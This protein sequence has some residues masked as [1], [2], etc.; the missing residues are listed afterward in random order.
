MVPSALKPAGSQREP[1]LP[2]CA[3]EGRT[4][5][6]HI[7]ATVPSVSSSKKASFFN[8]MFNS[9]K[10]AL[11]FSLFGVLALNVI[12]FW[13]LIHLTPKVLFLLGDLLNMTG[14]AQVLRCGIGA[15][16]RVPPSLPCPGPATGHVLPSRSSSLISAG[17]FKTAIKLTNYETRNSHHVDRAHSVT[18]AAPLVQ[19]QGKVTRV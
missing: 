15:H 7:S 5:S 9:I 18:G 11:M 12:I 16:V 8:K 14:H 1:A 6:R 4:D 19:F 17:V 10:V 13:S 2:P 3:R